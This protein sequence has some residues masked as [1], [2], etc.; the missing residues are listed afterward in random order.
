[1]R[2]LHRDTHDRHDPDAETGASTV[3]ERARRGEAE[4]GDE[5]DRRT[6]PVEREAALTR[7]RVRRE[8][9]HAAFHPGNILAV[10]GGAALAVIGAVALV[11]TGIDRS[12]DT[13]TEPVLR[14][15]HT[16]LLGAIEVG[17]GVLLILLGL[18]RVRFLALVG[19]VALAVV[20]AIAALE[21]GRLASDYALETWWAWTIAAAAAFVSLVLFLPSRRRTV[22]E[23]VTE[24][25]AVGR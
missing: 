24:E 23:D 3:D 25:P 22:E 12:W 19:T 2:L 21:P 5:R 7:H 6:A 4:T 16:A 15:D 13:P 17:I 11:R 20:A 10:I 8:R 1:M 14:I 9:T 18:S